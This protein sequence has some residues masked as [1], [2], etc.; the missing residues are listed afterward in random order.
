MYATLKHI[1]MSFAAISIILFI[2][3]FVLT[4]EKPHLKEKFYFDR[5]P[6]IADTILV[7]SA[8]GMTQY[9]QYIHFTFSWLQIKLLFVVLY[10]IFGFI[11]Y[12]KVEVFTYKCLF[13][14]LSL[15]SFSIV[16]KIAITKHLF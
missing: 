1:H 5:L 13:F 12:K 7:V 4:I 3:R 16:V 6:H 15:I 9:F 2:V 8:I 11:A 10:V 14:A